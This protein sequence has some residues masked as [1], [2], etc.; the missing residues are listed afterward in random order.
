MS[1]CCKN[2]FTIGQNLGDSI[3]S[4]SGE[5]MRLAPLQGLPARGYAAQLPFVARLRENRREI[6]PVATHIDEAKWQSMYD[7]AYKTN[8]ARIRKSWAAST[9]EP[10][11]VSAQEAP[12][13]R[14]PEPTADTQPHVRAVEHLGT[15]RREVAD[16]PA[17]SSRTGTPPVTPQPLREISNN[18]AGSNKKPSRKPSSIVAFSPFKG[19]AG[20]TFTVAVDDESP[21]MPAH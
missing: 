2:L 12:P 15:P 13:V 9:V 6:A 14:M 10:Q 17:T 20:L 7:E 19:L 11:S 4:L 16:L 21:P 5:A 18:V 8:L 1:R 3:M